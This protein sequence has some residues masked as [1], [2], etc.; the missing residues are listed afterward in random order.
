MSAW[1]AIAGGPKEINNVNRVLL[2]ESDSAERLVLS[3]RLAEAG[4]QVFVTESGAQGL[5][6]ARQETPDFVLL[7]AGLTGGTTASEVIQRLKSNPATVGVPVLAYG[8]GAV[9]AELTQRLY[10]VGC[11]AVLGRS[12]VAVIESVLR[13]HQRV[14]SRIRELR[15]QNR[16]IASQVR[17][18]EERVQAEGEV[19]SAAAVPAPTGLVL[20]D[21]AGTVRNAD[22]GAMGIFGP[23][24]VGRR[25]GE[26]APGTGLEAFVRD[27]HL[28]GRR[29]L[30]FEL[31][32]QGQLPDRMLSA[33]VIPASVGTSA[34]GE[35]LRALLL[36]ERS[37]E[38]QRAEVI[39]AS[40]PT[41]AI[42]AQID[43]LVQ[44]ARQ[45]YTPA[46]L[47]GT[48]PAAE[49]LRRTVTRVATRSGC[50]L[51]SGEVGTE[52]DLVARILH[53]SARSSGP[54]VTFRCGA[55]G[56]ASA[57]RE[58]LGDVR[59]AS[60]K[61]LLG[62]TVGGT[63]VLED[64]HLLD[65]EVQ[66]MLGQ[67][68]DEGLFAQGENG[69]RLVATT[70]VDL[71]ERA[72]R[73]EFDPV[74]LGHLFHHRVEVPSLAERR[75]DVPELA[76]AILSRTPG[77]KGYLTLT[78]SA[79]QLLAELDWPG[80]QEELERALVEA[81]ERCEGLELDAQHLATGLPGDAVAQDWV[82]SIAHTPPGSPGSG[83]RLSHGGAASQAM[84]WAITDEDPISLDH[85]EMKVL[86][87]ALDA[88]GGD[89]LEAARL[90]NLGKSTLYRKLKRFG[91]R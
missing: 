16:L 31:R 55:Y 42:Q 41:G 30:R 27:S 14:Q 74:L 48:S 8:Q 45:H 5:V 28:G 11:D 67:R 35:P 47:R 71:E 46:T 38:A 6:Q 76:R 9:A 24:C 19:G 33:L 70:T 39:E 90:L 3:S 1:G 83:P 22:R 89:K 51:I 63:L 4:Y 37:L 69:V 23:R 7:S 50:V 66:A 84:P 32:G 86:L 91:I 78:E 53:W 15:S 18:L 73:E 25:L 34:Q 58:L 12:E 65:R 56:G 52:R 26:L 17:R 81:A 87:R 20:V 10:E 54:L 60:S 75:E 79:S 2:V 21:E 77:S 29:A 43:E 72:D 68:L 64:V 49:Q 82:R 88:T 13:A 61:G 57:R 80:N 62:S 44:A 85:Y 36:H 40:E 59:D